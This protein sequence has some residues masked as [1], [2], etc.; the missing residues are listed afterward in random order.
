VK[1]FSAANLEASLF[2]SAL[3]MCRAAARPPAAKAMKRPSTRMGRRRSLQWLRAL[4]TGYLWLR[5]AIASTISRRELCHQLAGKRF[6]SLMAQ[7][8]QQHH[9]DILA[10]APHRRDRSGLVRCMSNQQCDGRPH[11]RGDETGRTPAHL[12]AI[13]RRQSAFCAP[14][15]EGPVD[16]ILISVSQQIP[17]VAVASPR[18]SSNAWVD[19]APGATSALILFRCAYEAFHP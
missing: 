10:R 2:A 8:E 9:L 12:S 15:P 3:A 6:S 16:L 13:T 14:L 7:C 19:Y 4:K 1:D 11:W 17:P 5:E 18:R